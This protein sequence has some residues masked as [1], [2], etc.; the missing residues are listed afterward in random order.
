[1]KN[2]QQNQCKFQQ[3]STN[4]TSDIYWFFANNIEK[5]EKA[6]INIIG[7]KKSKN[8]KWNPKKA[9][10]KYGE[11]LFWEIV[12]IYLERKVYYLICSCIYLEFV[13]SQSN[14]GEE[15]WVS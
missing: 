11:E 7:T 13:A 3:I 12:F 2:S 1:M 4:S 6:V 9:W 14:D 8:I 5:N 15:E 10:R